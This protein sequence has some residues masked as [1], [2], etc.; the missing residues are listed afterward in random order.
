MPIVQSV[1]KLTYSARVGLL[2]QFVATNGAFQMFRCQSQYLHGERTSDMATFYVLPSR[3]LL[4]QRFSDMLIAIFPDAKS[5]PRD[6]PD[7]AAALAS[8]V[9]GQGDAFVVFREDLDDQVSVKDALVRDFGAALD[10]DIV[11]VNFGPGLHEVVHQRWANERV[12]KAA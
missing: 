6:R 9:E 11:E 7:L 3:Q 5:T 8:I 10:D 4:G 1:L 2:F 12:K